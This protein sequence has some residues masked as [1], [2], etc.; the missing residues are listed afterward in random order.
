[1]IALAATSYPTIMRS[2]GT[3]WVMAM[4]RFGQ[5]CSPLAIGL[6]LGLGSSPGRI[7]AVMAL[8]PLLGGVCVLLKSALSAGGGTVLSDAPREAEKSA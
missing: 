3:G 4:G 6:M 7:L 5:V 2:A 1:M 8:A